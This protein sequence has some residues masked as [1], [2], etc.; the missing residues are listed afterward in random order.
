MLVFEPCHS[1]VH[2]EER[3]TNGIYGYLSL[4]TELSA[5]TRHSEYS[6]GAWT[7]PDNVD[8]VRRTRTKAAAAA[9]AAALSYSKLVAT[10]THTHARAHVHIGPSQYYHCRADYTAAYPPLLNLNIRL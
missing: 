4:R 5:V 8:S 1:V 9:A 2:F 7:R 3:Q 6:Y 10:H